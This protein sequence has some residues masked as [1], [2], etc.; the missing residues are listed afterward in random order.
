[1]LHYN[2][3][4][5]P[6]SSSLAKPVYLLNCL[7]HNPRAIIKLFLEDQIYIYYDSTDTVNLD[8]EIFMIRSYILTNRRNLFGDILIAYHYNTIKH[9]YRFKYSSRSRT[10][11]LIYVSCIGVWPQHYLSSFT[12]NSL[13]FTL[14][15]ICILLVLIHILITLTLIR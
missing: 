9:V 8:N 13:L 11:R 4:P 14:I 1:M 3:N 2:L 10:L 15:I 7:S 12:N 5:Y 6:Y